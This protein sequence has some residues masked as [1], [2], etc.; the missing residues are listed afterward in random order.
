M[1]ET[2]EKTESGQRDSGFRIGERITDV[3]FWRNEVNTELEKLVGEAKLLSE[4]VRNIQKAQQ[5]LETPL[6]IAQECLYHREGRQGMEKTHDH[7]EKSL[8]IE[9]DNLRKAQKKLAELYKKVF[10]KE[11]I[12]FDFGKRIYFSFKIFTQLKDCRAAQFSLEEDVS[13][14]ESAIGIDSVCHQ[15]NN[16]SRGINYY[17]GIENYDPAVST[18]DSWSQ[19]S[20]FRVNK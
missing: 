12:I 9:I 18:A 17:G 15:L 11:K 5:D 2:D 1:R 20:S 3:T 13:H 14:K 16:F 7:V 6:H 4:I 8:L 19:A 10:F